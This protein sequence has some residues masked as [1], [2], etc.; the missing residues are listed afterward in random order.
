MINNQL[1]TGDIEMPTIT[2]AVQDSG[3]IDVTIDEQDENGEMEIRDGSRSGA[4]AIGIIVTKQ[5]NGAIEA[6]PDESEQRDG[7]P[8]E[9]T[10]FAAAHDSSN[11]YHQRTQTEWSTIFSKTEIV[12]DESIK[13]TLF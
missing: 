13:Q 3:A 11:K 9:P 6:T 2:A 7:Y 8:T 1:D 4:S 12:A 5:D 10:I